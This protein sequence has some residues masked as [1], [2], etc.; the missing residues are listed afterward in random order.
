MLSRYPPALDSRVTP[1][2]NQVC[3]YLGDVVQDN[4]VNVLLPNNVFDII[5]QVYVYDEETLAQELPNMANGTLFL[6][7]RPRNGNV[8]AV[9]I[10]TINYLP[11]HYAPLLMN[12]QGYTPQEGWG[13]LVLQLQQDNLLAA[14]API[15]AWFHATFHASPPNNTGLPVT[16]LDLVAPFM[17]Q[18]L[19]QHRLQIR[20][21]AGLE[22][23]SPG[24]ETTLATMANA[25]VTQNNEARTAW[26]VQEMERDQPTLPSAKFNMLFSSLKV[27]LNVINEAELPTF[28]FTLAASPKKQEF[29]TVRDFLDKYS[30]SAE[31]FIAVAP[32]PNPKLLFCLPHSL[33]MMKMT[34]RQGCN[35]S[36]LWTGRLLIVRLHRN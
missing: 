29:S 11:T 12:N 16:A 19:S 25:L 20:V 14:A 24:F 10:R 33:Q 5:Q 3:A 27:M 21:L 18:D 22:R 31:A 36:L 8:I 4:P 23:T 35:P 15:I 32:I 28:W 2:D 34:S 13:Q 26:L 1:W 7:G 9:K 30:R 17:D 6:R